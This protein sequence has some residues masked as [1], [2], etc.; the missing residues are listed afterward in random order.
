MKCLSGRQ[1]WWWAIVHKQKCIEN[2]R[3]NLH[4]RGEFLLHAAQGCTRAELRTALDWMHE[5]GIDISDW[6][7]LAN[8]QRGGIIGRAKLVDVVLPDG[9][10]LDELAARHNVD[11]RWWMPGQYGFVLAEVRPLPFVAMKGSLGFF[12]VELSQLLSL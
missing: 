2:R 9:S 10:N 5:R 11:P 7:G 12:D 4:Y 8:V 6:P 3:W 1:P